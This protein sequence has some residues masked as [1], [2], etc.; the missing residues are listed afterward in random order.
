MLETQPKRN[1]ADQ[2]TIAQPDKTEDAG[3]IRSLTKLAKQRSPKVKLKYIN[4]YEIHRVY[5]GPEEGGIYGDRAY[6]EKSWVL[7]PEQGESQEYYDMRVDTF[8]EDKQQIVEEDNEG[9]RPLY[10]VLSDGKLHIELDN[11]PAYLQPEEPYHY[12]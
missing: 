4:L 10:S 1:M 7:I 5:L 8:L 9:R 6:P 3:L 2:I 12:E 11:R